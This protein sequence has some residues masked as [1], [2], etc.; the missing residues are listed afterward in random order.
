MKFTRI[1]FPTLISIAATCATPAFAVGPY[2]G[3]I[4]LGTADL[5]D[6][7]GNCTDTGIKILG[8]YQVTPSVAAE[9]VYADLGK[10]G[11]N[12]RASA[13]G[14]YAVGKLPLA[15]NFSLLGRL[16]INNARLKGGGNSDSG[17]EL[18]YGIGA[19]YTLT[20]TVDL[21]GEWERYQFNSVDASLLSVG[22]TMKF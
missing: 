20:P 13:L 4:S 21:R 1:I 14:L 22:V 18:G 15:N 2:Y 3:G 16:G 7:V 10:F 12:V 9:I 6:C 8:G 11:N 17:M 19:L 5:Q